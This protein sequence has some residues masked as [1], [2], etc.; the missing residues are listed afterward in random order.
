VRPPLVLRLARAAAGADRGEPAAPPIRWTGEGSR[1]VAVLRRLLAILPAGPALRALDG[2]ARLLGGRPVLVLAA[3]VV[4]A[5]GCRL[6]GVE[7]P[8]L[9]AGLVLAAGAVCLSM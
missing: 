4:L 2:A 8:V 7:S 9:A 6:L 5:P 3:T 1:A